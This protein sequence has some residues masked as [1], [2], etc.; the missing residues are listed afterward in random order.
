MHNVKYRL[1]DIT[2]SE[3]NELHEELKNKVCYIAYLNIGERGWFLYDTEMFLE[4]VHRI[5]TS[6][7]KNVE[8][9]R[10]NRVIL[11]TEHTTYVFKAILGEK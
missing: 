8:Y 11:T 7:V 2:S 5:H 9:T 3:K 6:I 1:T 4:P 10:D